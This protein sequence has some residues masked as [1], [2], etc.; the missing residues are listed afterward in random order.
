MQTKTILYFLL[1]ATINVSSAYSQTLF[2]YG[3]KTIGKDEFLKAFNKNPDTVG[4]NSDNLRQY[5]DLYVNFKLKIQAAYDEKMDKTESYKTDAENFRNRLTDNFINEQANMNL[6]VHE[7]FVRSQK[8]I[9]LAEV[10]VQAPTGSDTVHAFMQISKAYAELKAGKDFEEVVAAYSSDALEKQAKGKIG[11]ITVFTL[12]YEVE[13][14]VYA[15]KPG[16][17]SPV[18][19]SAAGYHIFENINERSALGKRKIQQVLIQVPSSFNAAEKQEVYRK[20]DS[21]Y[22]VLKN[23]ASFGDMVRLY[24]PVSTNYN[25]N[26]ITEVNVGQYSSDFENQVYAMQKTDDISKPFATSYGYHIIKLLGIIPVSRDEYDGVGY[27]YLQDRVQRDNRLRAAK[28][29]L[30]QQWL[31]LSRY[32]ANMY[33]ANDLWGFTDSSLNDSQPLA[34]K[35]ITPE[36]VL[37]EF[38]KQKI[39]AGDWAKFAEKARISEEQYSSLPYPDLMKIFINSSC[40]N[41]YRAHIEDFHPAIK[42]QMRE[43]NE[44]NLLFAVMDKHVWG[45]ASQDTGGLKKYYTAH[46]EKY[47]WAPGVSALVVSS[48]SKELIDEL[49]ARLKD[50]LSNWRNIV[51]SYDEQVMTDSSRF[52]NGQLPINGEV[53][54]QKGFQPYPEKNEAGDAYTFIKVFE[55]FPQQEPRSFDDA[56]GMVM[57]DYQQMLEDEWMAVLKKK[58]PVKINEDVLKSLR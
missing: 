15:L 11:F 55:V 47:V 2:T 14:I 25:E 30:I 32:K 27:S 31:V 26:G 33:N 58:Y 46:K 3:T 21:I 48:P 16:E 22:A 7:A 56:R 57:N 49:A 1:I 28:D 20:A 52:E 37:F 13:N 12:P 9:E 6:L 19:K 24:S 38:A 29:K 53:P 54:M 18:Y 43:F 23:G 5:F 4:N 45:K 34:Y 42:D 44:A 35:S 50:S 17:Y 10:F 51:S 39:T 36:T 8:D 40:D 41:Y